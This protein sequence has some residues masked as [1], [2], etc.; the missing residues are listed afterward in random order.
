MNADGTVSKEGVFK[1][2]KLID[3]KVYVYENGQL[4]STVVYQ[5]GKKSEK[6]LFRQIK[7]THRKW[8]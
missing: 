1:D 5:G 3:G 4:V 8:N 2:K 6:R 7:K